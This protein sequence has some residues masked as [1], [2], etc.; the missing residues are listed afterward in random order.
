MAP[1]VACCLEAAD[2]VGE[3]IVWDDRRNALWWVDIGGRR[4]HRFVP[5]GRLHDVW[6]TPDFPTSIGLRADGGFIVGLT[7]EV[8]RWTPGGAFEPLA[9]PE[10]DLPDNRLNEGRV[11]PDGSFWVGTMQNNL[12]A[13]GQPK[14]ITR[15]SGA[16]YRIAPDGTTKQLTPR[17]IGIVNTMAWAPGGRFVTADTLANT[18]YEYDVDLAAAELINRRVFARGPDRGFPDGSCLDAS[19]R[20]WNC[21]VAEGAALARFAPGGALEDLIDLPCAWPTSCTF[22]GP[23]LR[24]LYVTSARFTMTA[25]R[26]RA[27]PLEGGLF[28]LDVGV[29]GVLEHRFAG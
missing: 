7:R 13:E 4:I 2:I 19:G 10:P 23:E 3:S 8:Y 16:I 9:T 1:M 22:G 6:P 21:R 24:T 18:L 28:A 5:A 17:E 25:E 29:A 12:T 27:N 20:I 26:V 11:A 15:S 14:D